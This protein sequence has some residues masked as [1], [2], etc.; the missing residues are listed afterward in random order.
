MALYPSN[1]GSEPLYLYSFQV[2]QL[3]RTP[4]SREAEN[5]GF[6]RKLQAK[7]TPFSLS[8]GPMTTRIPS[9][10]EPKSYNVDGDDQLKQGAYSRVVGIKRK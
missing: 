7:F 4:K 5:F 6:S 8:D 1:D 9:S 2:E 3:N 10:D